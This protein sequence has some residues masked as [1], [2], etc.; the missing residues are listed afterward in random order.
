MKQRHV[1]PYGSWKSPVTTQLIANETIGLGRIVLDGTDTYWAEVRPSE[2]GREVIVKRSSDG[3]NV[4]VTP[5]Q[6]GVRS[7]VHEYGARGYTV[8]GGVMYFSNFDDRRL[9]R[10]QPGGE[11]VP[12]TP[13]GDL[14]YAAM[15]VDQTRNRIIC[16]REDHTTGDREAVNTI[17]GIDIDGL[18]EVKVLDSGNDFYASPRLS[19]DGSALAWLAW[20]HPDMPWDGTTLWVAKFNDE[21][22]LR[23]PTFVAG[24]VPQAIAQPEW[25][26]DGALYFVSD[27]SNWWNLY[28]WREGEV[29][30]V[31]LMEA[32]F[33]KTYWWVGMS[34]F[35]F[36]SATSIVCSYGRHGVWRLG[37]LDLES[38]R[39]D[40]LEIPYSSMGHGDLKVAAGRVVVEAGSPVRPMSVLE[41][42]LASN[43]LTVLQLSTTANIPR[44]FLSLPEPIEYPTGNGATAHAFYY[45]PTNSD[46]VAPPGEKPPLLVT[47]HGGPTGAATMDL[48]LCTQYWTSRGI[49]V[50]DVNYGGSTG[51]GRDYRERLMGEWGVVDVDD[52]TKGALFLTA[53]G[54]VDENRLM[55]SGGSAGGFTALAAMTFRDVFKA[56][57]SH[58]GVS[59]L[60]ALLED[61]HKF[62][63]HSL[64]A[65][66]GPYPLYR[67]K[68]VER[69]PINFA[70]KLSCP[71]I[72]F[73]GLD[74]TIVPADQSKAMFE[75]LR[76][77][78]VATAYLTFE[79][80]Q[81]G[82]QKSETIR[83]V[84]E[85][86]LYFYSRVFGFETD[87]QIPPVHIENM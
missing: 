30:P 84:L 8:A 9:Y 37:R 39:L 6:F 38:G 69:S 67:K 60:E 34:A 1:A 25:S 26:P 54:D 32:D 10:H 59:D 33:A 63:T 47:C 22:M 73:Q 40:P 64:L 78:G 41:L 86:E 46:Y 70:E 2:E 15:L 82:F 45:P 19:P 48:D 16:V 56:G 65:L 76:D 61:I 83:R 17:V 77:K 74:D 11:P 44:E 24:G 51:Y 18:K 58:F 36:E 3:R 5:D 21:G 85:A 42:N 80:E 43:E 49:A 66:V 62:D 68:Y 4:D 57:A 20:N 31:L 23:A 81:H 29:E 14:R 7:A 71:V 50:L 13:E 72:F 52:S 75:V 27:T 53:R 55:I 28:R 12:I 79:G 87:D 35:G